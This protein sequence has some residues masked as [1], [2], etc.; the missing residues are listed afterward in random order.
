[1]IQRWNENMWAFFI[2]SWILCLDESMLIWFQRWTCSGWVFC[3]LKPHPFGNEYHSACCGLSGMMFSI[4]V[5]EGKD[6]PNE[7][8]PPEYDD[9]G[10]KTIGSM[11]HMLKSVF[12]SG[13]YVVLNS[14][15]CIL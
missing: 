9:H 5:I 4:K 3:P 1:M 12:P 11:L 10:G 13:W 8:G 7:L 15:F 6:H 2:P 14:G